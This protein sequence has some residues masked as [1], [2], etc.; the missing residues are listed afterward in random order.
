MLGG[1]CEHSDRLVAYVPLGQFLHTLGD[2]AA[3]SVETIPLLQT[4]QVRAPISS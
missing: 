3:I 2:V 4:L 1:H